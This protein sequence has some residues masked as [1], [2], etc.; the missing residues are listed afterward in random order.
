MTE[1]QATQLR[2]ER[3]GGGPGLRRDLAVFTR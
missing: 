3:L 2:N 1:N